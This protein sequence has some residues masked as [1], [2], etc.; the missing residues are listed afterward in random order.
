MENEAK[1]LCKIDHSNILIALGITKWKN[2]CGI[3]T[4][5]ITCGNLED[6]LRARD[7]IEISWKL[8]LR[9]FLELGRAVH[10]L[11]STKFLIHGDIKPQNILLDDHLT[12]KLADFGAA[13]II[14]A[15]GVDSLSA[16]SQHK[17]HDKNTEHTP[18]YTAPEYLRNVY[19]EKTKAMDIYRLVF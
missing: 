13:D 15:A 6:L 3:I 18:A 19:K 12:I 10:Y 5:L 8:R 16:N 2:C 11:H 17:N 1:I 4:E 14:K 9:F 7:D